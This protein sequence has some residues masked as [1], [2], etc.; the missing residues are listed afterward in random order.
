VPPPIPRL[1]DSA[2]EP[3]ERSEPVELTPEA[4]EA[5]D[6]VALIRPATGTVAKGAGES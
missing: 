2:G 1:P 3:D 4:P 6:E 5:D